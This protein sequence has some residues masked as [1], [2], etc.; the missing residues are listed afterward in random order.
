MI[1]QTLKLAAAS[2]AFLVVAAGVDLRPAAVLQH[3]IDV[4]A[5]QARIGR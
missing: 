3:G 5:A 4:S 2:L 1:K